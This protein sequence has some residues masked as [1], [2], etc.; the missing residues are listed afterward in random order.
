[1]ITEKST[2]KTEIIYN[3]D[4]THRFLLKKVWDT[5]L[6][7]AGIIMLSPS[8]SNE[9]S[10][11]MTTTYIVNRLHDLGYGSVSILNIYSKINTDELESIADNDDFIIKSAQKDDIFII[12]WGKGNQNNK[13]VMKRQCEVLAM[14]KPY[15]KKLHQIADAVGNFGFH[16]LG[17]SVRLAWRLVHYEYIEEQ[18]VE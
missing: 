2:M 8:S 10:Q 9:I 17:S 5:T 13:S 1:M 18:K 4:K 12:A 16:P 11:D 3:D 7:S 6:P 15:E 14:L